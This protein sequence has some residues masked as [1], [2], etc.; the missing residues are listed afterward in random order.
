LKFKKALMYLLKISAAVAIIWYM[1]HSGSINFNAIYQAKSNYQ[2]ILVAL[3]M[4]LVGTLITFYR[5]KLLLKGQNI[6]ISSKDIISMGFIGLFFTSVLPGAV[7]GDL[8]KSVYIAKRVKANKTSSVLT[9]L[10]DRIIGMVALVIICVFGLLLN[11]K[12]VLEQPELRSLALIIVAM[13]FAFIL[14]TFIGLSKTINKNA[15]FNKVM[16]KVPFSKT[17]NKV[18]QAFHAYRDAHKYL[19]YALLLSFLN[20]ALNVIAF[21]I[22][23]K[24]LGFGDLGL[25]AYAFIVPIG[26]ITTAIPITPAGIGIGQ[27][28]YLKLFEWSLGY[29]TTI[30]ADAITIWQAISI[31]IFMAGGYFYI[32][33]RRTLTE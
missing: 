30:G 21:Y 7:G 28:A 23:T 18:Y 1:V 8:I 10:L 22:I 24:A 32:T 31:I 11:F 19:T 6:I 5:W 9:V 4:L 33:Y 14:F 16:G 3:L 20:Q 26:M 25:Y 2:L 13:L 12:K 27:A 17:F 29:P 15:L